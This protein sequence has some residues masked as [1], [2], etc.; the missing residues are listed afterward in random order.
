MHANRIVSLRRR[1]SGHLAADDLAVIDTPVPEVADGTVL[2]RN[3]YLSVD[4]GVRNLLGSDK[5]HM[6]AVPVGSALTGSVL[7]TV[8][9]SRHPDYA[10]GD[11]VQGRGTL[12]EYSLITPGPLTWTVDPALCPDLTMAQGVL[13]VPGLTA[14]FGLLELARP[15]AGET[16]LVSSAAGAV[17]S[18]AAQLAKAQG[19]RTVGI[20]GGT[21]KC[22]YL[23]EELGLDA[24]VDHHGKGPDELAA[25][26][27]AACPNGIDA[28][29]DNVGGMTLDSAL[30]AMNKGGRI[31]LC[32]MISQYDAGPAH[33]F[34]HLFQ[35]IA[36]C[37]TL[38]GFLLFDFVDRYA[39][40][41]SG[42]LS[43][44]QHGKLRADCTVVDGIE[45]FPDA[46]CRV[47]SGAGTGKTLV[48][49]QHRN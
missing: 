20:A 33:R 31:S 29:F 23:R 30:P 8:V 28:F 14:W 9:A 48:K 5:G 2:L 13:G 10:E 37:L 17:G 26:I 24:A 46:L 49:L 16:V 25:A 27:G 19:C 32:G 47:F 41:A 36:K 42:L 18:V 44:V 4:P 21:A 45:A 1:P 22:A 3:L 43:L 6:P 15:L 35:A 38:R 7:G 11:T 40:A 39:E 34:E 12:G